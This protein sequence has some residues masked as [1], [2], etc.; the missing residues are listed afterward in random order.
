MKKL[1]EINKEIQNYLNK[2]DNAF[3][4]MKLWENGRS[5]GVFYTVENGI[6]KT[7]GELYKADDN[8]ELESVEKLLGYILEECGE[9]NG[10]SVF[11][12]KKNQEPEFKNLN[13]EEIIDYIVIESR[14]ELKDIGADIMQNISVFYKDEFNEIS[15]D[16]KCS[17][18]IENEMKSTDFC[19]YSHMNEDLEILNR[20]LNFNLKSVLFEVTKDSY[21]VYSDP[22]M[23]D[24]GWKELN[25]DSFKVSKA[26]KERKEAIEKSIKIRTDYY[27]SFGKVNNDVYAPIL[28]PIFSGGS[29]WPGGRPQYKVI[30]TEKS[31]IIIT[32]GLSNCFDNERLDKDLKYNGYAA[33]LYFEFEGDIP[34]E[35]FHNHYSTKLLK[36]LSQFTINDGDF[37][38]YFAN[39]TT[40]SITLPGN[41]FPNKYR[42]EEGNS[43]VMM[44]IQSENIPAKIKLNIEDVL[45]VSCKLL[46]TKY[47]SACNPEDTGERRVK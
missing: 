43:I 3:T 42:D 37:V 47:F 11:T 20:K 28:S 44:N 33:E 16:S 27:N 29:P 1:Q 17:I 5:G 31:T 25:A 21:T 23:P 38:S 18:Y 45:L 26:M 2:E 30:K 22:V 32:D 41:D 8:D 4:V 10:I 7:H 40:A 12:F 46:P 19:F 35:D 39:S 6:T 34:F 14:T 9:I 13:L 15:A 24:L 36:N